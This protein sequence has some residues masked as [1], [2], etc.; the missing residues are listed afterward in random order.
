MK[1][2]AV[3]MTF[4]VPDSTSRDTLDE[5][6]AEN[7]PLM[8]SCSSPIINEA[9][10]RIGLSVVEIRPV[11]LRPLTVSEQA[12]LVALEGYS[13]TGR[14]A[15]SVARVLGHEHPSNAARVLDRLVEL[16]LAETGTSPS[17]R[18]RWWLA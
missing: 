10:A 2:V 9:G 17:G 15:T 12:A 6:L 5:I 16:G 1:H 3:T 8:E 13:T 4:T 14:T 7:L 18:R 11:P